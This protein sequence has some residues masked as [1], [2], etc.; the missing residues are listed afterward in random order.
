MRLTLFL[1]ISMTL[2]SGCGDD[3]APGSNADGGEE[4][5]LASIDACSFFDVATIQEITGE[6]VGFLDDGRADPSVSACFWGAR[7]PGFPAYVELSISRYG[8]DIVAA[9]DPDC[10]VSTVDVED[11]D[12]AGVTCPPDPQRKIYLLVGDQGIKVSLLVNE[13]SRPI[14]PEDL[15]PFVESIVETL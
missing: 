15:V 3:G 11:V 2:L 5:D 8:G 13:P 4:I 7:E 14:T 6:K 1:T 12:S 10:T 9:V